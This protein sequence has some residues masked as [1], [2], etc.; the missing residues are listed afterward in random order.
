M[1]ML[2]KN[3]ASPCRYGTGCFLLYNTGT[4]VRATIIEQKSQNHWGMI[5]VAMQDLDIEIL[6]AYSIQTLNEDLFSVLIEWD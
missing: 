4:E 2:M 6:A 3:S 5:C 1:L